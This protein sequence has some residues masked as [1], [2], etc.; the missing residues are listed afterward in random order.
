MTESLVVGRDGKPTKSEVRTS[1]GVFL[2]YK[3]LLASPL[4]RD[5]ERRLAEWTHTPVENGEN[6][7]LLQYKVNSFITLYIDQPNPHSAPG[8]REVRSSL[9]LFWQGARGAVEDAW[10][11]NGNHLDLLGCLRGRR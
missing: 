1:S 7:Y 2:G 8:R 3:Y 5:Y 6:F 10:E 4:L 9:R 11:P